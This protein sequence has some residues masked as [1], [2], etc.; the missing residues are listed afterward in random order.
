V[1]ELPEWFEAVNAD[2]RYQ[3][4]VIGRFAQAIVEEEIAGNRF[5]IRTNMAGVKVSWQ[6]TARRNDAWMRA[7]PFE[8]ERDK[9]DLERGF[10][11][12]PTEHGQPAEKGTEWARRPEAM[13][14]RAAEGAPHM[15]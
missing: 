8:A 13:H 6:V 3:L 5:A 7:H 10:Y 4:T 9:P 12:S 1:V 2:F 11:L 14:G 15:R